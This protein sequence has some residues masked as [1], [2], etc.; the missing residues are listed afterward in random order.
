MNVKGANGSEASKGLSC[1]FFDYLNNLFRYLFKKSS[2][3]II[4]LKLANLIEF[5]I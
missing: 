5:L 3:N 4:Q 1:I 2:F